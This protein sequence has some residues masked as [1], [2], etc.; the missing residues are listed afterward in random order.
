VSSFQKF[1]MCWL[2]RTKSYW[3]YAIRKMKE[4]SFNWLKEI[5]LSKLKPFLK[6]HFIMKPIDSQKIKTVSKVYW[7]KY[8]DYMEILYTLKENFQMLSNNIYWQLDGLSHL[9]SFENTLMC[10]KLIFWLSILKKY[11]RKKLPKK[12]IP[13]S[14]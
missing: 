10:L 2:M 9:M 6:D 13:L 11:M 3:L 14:C 8:P 7:L 4:W 5:I 12:N 1:K